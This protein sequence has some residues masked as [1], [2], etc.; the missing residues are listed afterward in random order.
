MKLRFAEHPFSLLDSAS[1]TLRHNSLSLYTPRL[2]QLPSAYPVLY[3]SPS[4]PSTSASRC[5]SFLCTLCYPSFPPLLA[6]THWTFLSLYIWSRPEHSSV[7]ALSTYVRTYC[8][9]FAQRSEYFATL[10]PS[11]DLSPCPH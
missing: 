3:R 4:T 9:R 2:R 10:E 6:R 8:R 1:R 5:C 11:C 7:L